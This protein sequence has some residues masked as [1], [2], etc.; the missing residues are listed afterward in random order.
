MTANVIPSLSI[1]P[2]RFPGDNQSQESSQ[3]RAPATFPLEL[4]LVL[5]AGERTAQPHVGRGEEY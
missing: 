3:S 1:N 5:V 2:V 4:C